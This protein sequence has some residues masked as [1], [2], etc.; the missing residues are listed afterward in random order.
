M[1]LYLFGPLSNDKV[2]YDCCVWPMMT[3]LSY[4]IEKDD[5]RITYVIKIIR[6]ASM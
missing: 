4:R 6:R 5:Y 3:I 2:L 1:F